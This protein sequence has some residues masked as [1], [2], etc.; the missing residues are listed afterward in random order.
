MQ[1]DELIF[2]EVELELTQKGYDTLEFLDL[3]LEF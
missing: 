2:M 1:T 3:K